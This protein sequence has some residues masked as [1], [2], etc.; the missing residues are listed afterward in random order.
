MRFI[1][2]DAHIGEAYKV[3]GQYE[4]FFLEFEAYP[5][6]EIFDASINILF[7]RHEGGYYEYQVRPRTKQFQ[8]LRKSIVDGVADLS[9]I[10]WTKNERISLGEKFTL[11]QLIAKHGEYELRI[12]HEK[13]Y[14]YVDPNPYL[15]GE[16]FIGAGAGETVP[17]TI[18]IDNIRVC[19]FKK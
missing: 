2:K 10:G 13:I 3:Y 18:D 4:K 16:I 1:I 14:T 19:G 6:G 9:G 17:I 8:F 15:R 11:M 5:V 12:N 7:L